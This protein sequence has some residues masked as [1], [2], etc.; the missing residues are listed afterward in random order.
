MVEVQA[1]Q[2]RRNSAD[3]DPVCTADPHPLYVPGD[4]TAKCIDTHA[5]RDPRF[6]TWKVRL[7]F[8]IL[9]REDWTEPVCKFF[10][11][12]SGPKPTVGLGSHYRR[13]WIRANGERPPKRADRMTHQLFRG[14]I[15]LIRV[16]TNLMRWES[17]NGKR[18]EH[19]AGE[20]YSTVKELIELLP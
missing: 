17:S 4:Y 19:S 2:R 6:G 13:A 14:R 8:Q 1:L 20:Q 11:L 15:Y 5:Y 10:N 9:D 7:D 16:G 3:F 12:G 18:L